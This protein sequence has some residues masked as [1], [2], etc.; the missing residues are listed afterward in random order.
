MT[1]ICFV[2]LGKMGAPMAANLVKAGYDVLA[3]DLVPDLRAA[4]A[5]L[6]VPIAETVEEA[7]S[8]AATVITML[9]TGEPVLSVTR[10]VLTLAAPGALFIDCSTID[11]ETARRVHAEVAAAGARSLDAPVSGGTTG[12]TAGTL[13]LMCGGSEA[14]FAAAEPLLLAMGSRVIHCGDAGCGQVAKICNNM[15]LGTIMAVTSEAFVLAENLGLSAQTL[16][17]V[18]STSSGNSFVMTRSCPVPDILAD[19]AASQGYKPGFTAALMLKDMRLSQ[20][21]AAGAQFAT[22]VAAKAAEQYALAVAAGH[23][24]EDY[25]SIIKYLRP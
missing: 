10:H 13:T 12:A 9:P 11:V 18:V 17:D 7:A 1:K 8:G 5:G 2:G 15:I 22:P 25:A 4:S 3:F 16:F 6:G 24:G 19:S 20:S 23:G 14:A 21:A